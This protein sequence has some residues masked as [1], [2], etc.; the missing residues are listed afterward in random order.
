M[1]NQQTNNGDDS[2]QHKC[3]RLG[4]R[5]ITLEH[6]YSDIFKLVNNTVEELNS[7]SCI[8]PINK[9]IY[10][11]LILLKDLNDYLVEFGS[12]LKSED[13]Q[14]SDAN[15]LLNEVQRSTVR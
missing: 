10:V 12:H 7:N 8:E 15:Y 3:P 9:I 2:F 6:V 5:K 4:N 13:I 11:T 1:Q 14:Q